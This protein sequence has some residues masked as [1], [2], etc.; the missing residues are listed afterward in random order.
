[1]SLVGTLS[2]IIASL[3]WREK[4]FKTLR[5][6]LA[7]NVLGPPL[8]W[9]IPWPTFHVPINAYSSFTFT[10]ANFL[11][12]FLFAKY[13][14]WFG[15]VKSGILL[16]LLSSIAQLIAASLGILTRENYLTA[17]SMIF[18]IK[19]TSCILAILTISEVS[20]VPEDQARTY[21]RILYTQSLIGYS[22]AIEVSRETI[23][24]TLRLLALSVVIATLYLI[25]RI[26]SIMIG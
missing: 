2:S 15:A 18:A 26:L 22:I 12:T 24:T 17:F 6:G 4:A 5:V 16:V 1:M 20:V 7:L 3:V 19:A 9:A 21:S 11:G 13:N 25:F 8:I 14:E 23:L 10:G